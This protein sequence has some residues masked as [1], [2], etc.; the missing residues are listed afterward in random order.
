MSVTP[1][2]GTKSCRV[3]GADALAEVEGF[4]ALPRVTS[5]CKPFRSG[6]SLAVCSGCGAVQKPA[7]DTWRAEAAEIYGAYTPYHSSG[8]T[9]QAV[10]DP[11][12]GTPRS[13]S[14]VILDRLARIRPL[15]ETGRVL[16]VGCGNGALLAAF[17]G[18]KPGWDL[19]G[20]DLS[21]INLA[22]LKPIPGFR[23]LHTGALADVPGR[24][25]LVTMMH[26]LEHFEH[27]AAGLADLKGLVGDGGCLLIEVPNGEATPFDL[28]VADHASHFTR[29]D[30]ARLLADGGWGTAAL[31]DDWVT[32]ELSAVALPESGSA[33]D[34]P[35]AP[36]PVAVYARVRAQIGW[37]NAIVAE[38]EAAAAE[39]RPFGLFGTSIAAT[40]LYGQLGDKISFF[41]DEDPSCQGRSLYGKPIHPPAAVP[42]DGIVYVLL[43]P[44]VA[45][46][47]AERLARTHTLDLRVPPSL[48]G[49]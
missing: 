39:G 16:D 13:R 14:A 17:A 22:Q 21:E 7:D 40:W 46:A 12:R 43:I 32:K 11:V 34:L 47:V 42:A 1:T 35:P 5:D 9:E 18:M 2:F 15:A 20:H 27:P 45:R 29:H 25:D 10:F 33:V 30:L 28:L 8:G 38:A 24:Y 19:Y 44:G 23:G 3:C 26:S 4:G 49:G 37:L 6:G 48:L 41:V 36:A 31:S